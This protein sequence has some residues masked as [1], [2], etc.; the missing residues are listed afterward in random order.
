[1]QKRTKVV[2]PE[3]L[4]NEYREILKDDFIEAL[5][6]QISGN[7]MAPFLIHQRDTVY[8]SRLKRP[9]KKGD[10][11]LYQRDNGAY[12]L[13]RVFKIENNHVSM[14]GD[15]QFLIETGIRFEQIIAIVTSVQR[16]GKTLKPGDF[17]W[18]FFEK[19]WIHMIP[20]R[21]GIWQFVTLMKKLLNGKE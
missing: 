14:I 6:F 13:H 1:M 18:E 10:I 19:C 11:V 4:M 2:S 5:P 7:S 9:V 12:V 3:T 20:F 16:N 15:G 8:L 21:K 17:W